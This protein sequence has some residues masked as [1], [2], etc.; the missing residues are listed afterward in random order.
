MDFRNLSSAFK[1]KV[2]G[3]PRIFQTNLRDAAK[4]VFRKGDFLKWLIIALVFLLMSVIIVSY[5]RATLAYIQSSVSRSSLIS[6]PEYEV[7]EH[8][9]APGET[10]SNLAQNLGLRGEEISEIIKASEEVYDLA[11]I[12]PET[13]LRVFF[14]ERGDCKRLEYRIGENSL[15][16]LRKVRD[17]F[18]AQKIETPYEIELR[19]VR[20]EIEESLYLAAREAGFCD[21]TIMELAEIFAWDIDFT[22]ETQKGDKFN[23]LYEKRFLNG[24]P[25]SPGKVLAASYGA[26]SDIYWAIYYKDPEGKEDYYDLEGKCLRR[27]FLRSPLQYKYISSGYSLR[28]FHPVW[29]IYTPHRAIDFAASCGTPVASVGAGTVSFAGWKNNIYGNTVIIRHGSVYTTYYSHL[30]AFAKGIKS[31]ARV[32][33]GQVIGFVGTTGTST[34]CH[35]DYRMKKHGAYVNPLTQKFPKVEPVK[36]RY[37][38]DFDAKKEEVLDLLRTTKSYESTKGY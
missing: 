18:I 34:G 27:Q 7:K 15:L 29:K 11:K 14:N 26:A 33:Q 31:G 30:S 10:F 28:R 38:E 36:E 21:K 24:T 32:L 35:L 25:A 8:K 13:G 20:G 6:W 23:V 2:L 19:L 17:K 22:Y 16:R 1:K 5:Q 9:I 4:I 3:L 12:K 37:L